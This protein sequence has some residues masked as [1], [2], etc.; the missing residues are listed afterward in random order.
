MREDLQLKCSLRFLTLPPLVYRYVYVWLTFHNCLVHCFSF[1]WKAVYKQVC[2]AVFPLSLFCINFVSS[3]KNKQGFNQPH[4]LYCMYRLEHEVVWK[5]QVCFRLKW[6]RVTNYNSPSPQPQESMF[7]PPSLSLS[8]SCLF[9]YLSGAL[10]ED[11]R[12]EWLPSL[13]LGQI[14]NPKW[15]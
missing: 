6:L 4:S 10:F 7:P 3:S 15:R 5:Y 1:L 9:V 14:H 8:L 13:A 12:E 11:H 2:Y